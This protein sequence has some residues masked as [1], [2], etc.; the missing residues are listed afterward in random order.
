MTNYVIRDTLQLWLAIQWCWRCVYARELLSRSWSCGMVSWSWGLLSCWQ[1]WWRPTDHVTDVSNSKNN[2]HSFYVTFNG[3]RFRHKFL[4]TNFLRML[5]LNFTRRKVKPREALS[6]FSIKHRDAIASF[7]R[8]VTMTSYSITNPRYFEPPISKTPS[9]FS[10][11]FTTLSWKVL[12]L[13]SEN[14]VILALEALSHYTRVSDRQ[15][16]PSD[17]LSRY[18]PVTD[19]DDKQ[20]T[21]S[22]KSRMLSWYAVCLSSVTRIFCHRH[23]FQ[24]LQSIT[25]AGSF[26][27]F[28]GNPRFRSQLTFRWTEAHYMFVC[29]YVSA[30][31]S[32]SLREVKQLINEPTKSNHYTNISHISTRRLNKNNWSYILS[33]T[34][35]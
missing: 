14:C 16:K 33:A 35:R 22:D 6:Y 31:C 20:S 24:I 13:F 10:V 2:S 34:I 28:C 5:S 26:R 8:Y 3:H 18:I 19:D 11:K 23:R 25:P 15:W 1:H 30:T 29:V 12:L 32:E 17:R 21:Y 4:I 27:N 7:S 9:N